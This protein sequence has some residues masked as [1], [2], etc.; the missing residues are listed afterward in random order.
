MDFLGP[1]VEAMKDKKMT[2]L[3]SLILIISGAVEHFLEFNLG[4]ALGIGLFAIYGPLL[5]C[6]TIKK[7]RKRIDLSQHNKIMEK[8]QEALDNSKKL[9]VRLKNFDTD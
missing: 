5:V 6:D 4:L 3:L 9:K 2:L 1:I 8:A 7:R